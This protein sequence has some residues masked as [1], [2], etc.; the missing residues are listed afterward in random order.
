M[1]PTAR[2]RL[3]S[4]PAAL[5][6]ALTSAPAV[7]AGLKPGDQAPVFMVKAHDESEFY[8]R[9]YCGE[10]RGKRNRQERNVLVLSFFATWCKPCMEEMPMLQE[11][12]SKYRDQGVLFY[13]VNKG[14][15]R[16]TVGNFLF[17]QVVSLPVLMD[18]YEV[19]S[20]KYGVR[21]L[22]T[23]AVIGGNGRLAEYHTGYQQ[24]YQKVLEHKLDSLLGKVLPKPQGTTGDS[25][26]KPKGAKPKRKTP[27]QRV[28]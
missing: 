12:A 13:L 19:I 28:N 4:I 1:N 26:P 3:L 21:E 20:K 22:P 24:G 5:A 17:E 11:M 9:D 15:T 23:L 16:D 8:L 27:G 14:Q 7:P 10:P 18:Q 25:V 6:L 2:T